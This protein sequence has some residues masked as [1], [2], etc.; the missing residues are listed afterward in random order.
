MKLVPDV[1]IGHTGNDC[2]EALDSVGAVYG[3]KAIDYKGIAILKFYHCVVPR[4]H[5]NS[6]SGTVV[7]SGRIK[8]DR[9]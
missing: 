6:R 5:K 1:F 3:A 8:P 9:G 2:L 7:P 4:F